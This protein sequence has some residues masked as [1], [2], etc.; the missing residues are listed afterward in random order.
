MSGALIN[1][2]L[3][4]IRTELE[5]LRDSEVITEAL[6]D[7]LDAAL[8]ARYQKDSKPWDVDVLGTS[9]FTPADSRAPDGPPP[10]EINN[11]A[12]SV[13]KVAISPPE[14]APPTHTLKPVGYCV[15]LYD[16]PAQQPE[17]LN[18]RKDDK[19]AIVEHLSEDW[20]KGYKNGGDPDKAGVFPANYVRSISEQEFNSSYSE[21]A[22]YSPAPQYNI[23]PPQAQQPQP[24][25][26]GYAQFPPP[27]TN[28]YPPQQYQP[29]PQAQP[30]PQQQ[31]EGNSGAG[32]KVEEGAKKFGKKLGNAAI[33][34]AGA[35]IGSNIV[36]SIF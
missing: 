16:F 13:A 20:W 31:E 9:S 17:D 10:A 5:F 4:T 1:R 22:Q 18:L 24:S 7:K 27:S 29:P 12:N 2:S 28:Y 36:N 15:A 19:I 30:E 35:T 3:T 26:G 21:K 23:P 6:F 32:N 25:Y 11:L 14:Y 8:P 33:F 34:G